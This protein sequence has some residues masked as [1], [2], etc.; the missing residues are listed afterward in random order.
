MNLNDFLIARADQ[1]PDD[2]V[3]VRHDALH[4]GSDRDGIEYK[5]GLLQPALRRGHDGL[6]RLDVRVCV[7]RL[8]VLV[9][10][11]RRGAGHPGHLEGALRVGKLLAGDEVLVLEGLRVRSSRVKWR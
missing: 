3:N 4:G 8:G 10:E 9:G 11:L 5:L 1:V 2:D 7:L 6:L